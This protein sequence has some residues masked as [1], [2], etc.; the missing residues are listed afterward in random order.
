MK[1]RHKHKKNLKTKAKTKKKIRHKPPG[2]TF[3]S[4]AGQYYSAAGIPDGT[5]SNVDGSVFPI[6]RTYTTLM[7]GIESVRAELL[8]EYGGWSISTGLTSVVAQ[9]WSVT[10]TV[11]ATDSTYYLFDALFTPI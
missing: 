5:P 11:T 1:T 8:R 4:L 10:F 7:L 3:A 9:G 6:P 2:V